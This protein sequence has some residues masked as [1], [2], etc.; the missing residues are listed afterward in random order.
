MVYPQKPKLH[1]KLHLWN[2]QSRIFNIILSCKYYGY[3][4]QMTF[5]VSMATLASVCENSYWNIMDKQKEGV[6]IV[7]KAVYVSALIR[8]ANEKPLHKLC[9]YNSLV[10]SKQKRYNQWV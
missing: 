6:R 3:L 9:H 8:K 4:V 7:T 1:I 2:L 5:C 10:L